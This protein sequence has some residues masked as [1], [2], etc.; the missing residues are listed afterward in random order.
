MRLGL[1]GYGKMGKEVERLAIERGWTIAARADLTL[2]PCPLDAMKNADVAIHFASAKTLLSD[3]Q[4]WAELKK[5]VVIGT[6][7]WNDQLGRVQT[8]AEQNGIGIL[9]AANF[10]LGVNIF[11][12]LLHTAAG[13]FDHLTEYDV[14]VH[15]IH[16]KDKI[17]SPSGTA[18]Q[19]ADILLQAIHRKTEVLAET[20]HTKIRPDQ[21]HVTSSRVGA[22]IGQHSVLFDSAA[23]SIELRHTAK[24]RTGMALGA[25]LAA[26]WIQNKKGVFTITQMMEDIF[27]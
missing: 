25:L 22:V 20:S 7:G 12:R 3:L 24:N 1:I 10:S 6:T 9:Y 11:Y 27:H 19:I 26:E 4:R 23:D 14:S 8:L 18:L 16:H 17:D 15:E 21:L 5:N 13:L 2:P